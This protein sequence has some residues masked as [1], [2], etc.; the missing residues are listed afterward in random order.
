MSVGGAAANLTPF[1]L[2]T[3]FQ[4][5]IDDTQ[6]L[7]VC[8]AG[9]FLLP[10]PGD[11][12]PEPLAIHEEQRPPPMADVHWGNPAHTSVRY[13]GQGVVRRQGAEIYLQGSAWA[14]RGP[15]VAVPTRIR[16]GSCEKSVEVIGDRFW[17]RGFLGLTP[18][19]PAPFEQM[20]LRYERAF[21]GSIHG[22]DGALVAH[23]A[24]NPTGRGFYTRERMS[25][26][27]PLHNLRK[28]GE[29]TPA[30]DTPSQPWGYGPIPPAWQPRLGFAGTYD[31]RWMA[32]RLPLWPRDLDLR[33][34]LAA[35]PGM[36]L[37]AP[38][39]GDEPVALEGFSPDGVFRFNLPSYRILSKSEYTDRVVRGALAL[40]GVLFEP[41]E[42]VVTLYWRR[43]VPLGHGRKAHLHTSVR[44]LEPWEEGLS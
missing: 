36:S 6:K 35:A 31:S 10:P 32:E 7:V 19:S 24:R 38:L 14:V 15:A 3:C 11:S 39:Q 13:A 12:R 26:D 23:E 41:E 34:F 40:D 28:P 5:D 18:S 8:V 9:R 42:G 22:D 17:R 20:P 16:V 1:A 27:K 37:P 44:L 2:T 4:Y 30:W 21:G 29:Q 25:L 43:V 33:F